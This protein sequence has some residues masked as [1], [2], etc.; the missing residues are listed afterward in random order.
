[1]HI[2]ESLWPPDLTK[3][4]VEKRISENVLVRTYPKLPTNMYKSFSDTAR[5]LPD[6]TALVD[7]WGRGYTYKDLSQK[8]QKFSSWLYLDMNVRKGQ[9]TALMLYNSVEFC[10]AFLSL[11]RIGAVVIPL[12]TKFK[13]EEVLS[14]MEKSDIDFVISDEQFASYFDSYKEKGISICRIPDGEKKYALEELEADE[15]AEVLQAEQE[16]NASDMALLMFTSG[17]TSQ[18]KG[19]MIKNYNVMHAIVSYQRT[20]GIGENDRAIIPVP[21]Y[22]ITGLVAV[23]G[24]LMHVGGTVYLNKFFEAGRVLEDIKKYEITFLH[25]SPTVFTLLLG[26]K[27][28]FKSLPSLRM[29]ACGSSNMSPGKIRMLHKWLPHCV[30]RTIYGLTETTSPGT[31]FPMDANESEYIGSSGIPIPG[32]LFKIIDGDGNEVPDGTEGEV[33]VKGSNITEAYYHLQT[34]AIQDGWLNTGDIG[35]FNSD[36]Y[37]YIVDRKKDMINRGGEKICSFDVEN[38]LLNI[39]GVEDASVVGIPDELYGEIPVS[40]VKLKQGSNLNEDI[41]KRMLKGKMAGYKI[42]VRILLVDEIPITK[43]MKTD[44]KKIRQLFY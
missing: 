3:D 19:V 8:I 7:N 40:V 18:S 42:P 43:N 30:F 22:L 39:E 31:V 38:E 36:G 11:N 6:K 4:M 32:L 10:V 27:D 12:P 5:R 14:L 44:K 21:I 15:T 24:L 23:F 9:H 13:E 33:L 1:M 29:F 26:M 35:Y 34:S 20:L 2:G 28:E 41:L 16:V 17:T 25:A 37:L